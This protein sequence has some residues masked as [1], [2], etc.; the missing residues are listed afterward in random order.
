MVTTDLQPFTTAESHFTDTKFYLDCNTTY[1]VPQEESMDKKKAKHK[2]GDEPLTEGPKPNSKVRQK[3]R[4][5]E[6]EVS[7]VLRYVPASK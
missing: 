4:E 6:K 2:E 7:M 5:K 3:F 1:D